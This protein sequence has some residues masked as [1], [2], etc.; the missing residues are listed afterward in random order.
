MKIYPLVSEY[1]KKRKEKLKKSY[2][3]SYEILRFLDIVSK[4]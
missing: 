4:M 2:E 3:L 1:Q